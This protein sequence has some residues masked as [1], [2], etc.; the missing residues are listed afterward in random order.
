MTLNKYVHNAETDIVEIVE[1]T[2]EEIS[3]READIALW[4]A[5][6]AEKV[7]E[8]Q[9]LRKAKEAAQAKLAVLGLTADD[10]KAL[11]L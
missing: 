11:G 9:E 8:E 2:S 4:Q 3:Q 10:L 1:M 6:K 7:A 5:D